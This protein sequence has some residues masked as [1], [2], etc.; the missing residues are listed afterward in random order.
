MAKNQNTST[1][2]QINSKF[3]ISMTKTKKYAY[4]IP[5]PC[6]EFV[7]LVI[8][9]YLL[10]AICYLLFVISGLSGLGLGKEKMPGI[11]RSKQTQPLQMED[12]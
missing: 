7:L 1:K 12:G 2:F 3:E 11:D 10:F 9:Y 8:G 4:S 5:H 6:F